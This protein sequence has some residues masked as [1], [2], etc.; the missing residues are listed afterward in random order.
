MQDLN[1]SDP[2]NKRGIKKIA[3]RH[4][5]REFQKEI[6]EKTFKSEGKNT[7]SDHRRLGV[8][9]G[10]EFLFMH[11]V[12]TGE[13]IA[14]PVITAVPHA[15]AWFLGLFSHRDRLIGLTDLAGILGHT[16]T[17]NKKTDK[18]LTCAPALSLHCAFR[19][20]R[21]VGLIDI[22]G[23]TSEVRIE[24]ESPWL[25]QDYIDTNKVKWTEINLQILINHPAFLNIAL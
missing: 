12:Q 24:K 8:Q 21:I 18:V 23:M 16:I 13:V 17:E 2:L 19:V 11:L 1:L 20:T 5:L 22:A 14:S 6:A 15:K 9:V 10:E 4:Q 7:A 3:R 25:R